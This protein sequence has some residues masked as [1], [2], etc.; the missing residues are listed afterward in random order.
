MTALEKDNAVP[1]SAGLD[2]LQQGA[3]IQMLAT[4]EDQASVAEKK[5]GS[6]YLVSHQNCVRRDDESYGAHSISLKTAR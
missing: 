1:G 6:P 5:S 3:S 4:K 2:A